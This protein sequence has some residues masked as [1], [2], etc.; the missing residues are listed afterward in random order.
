[1]SKKRQEGRM[2]PASKNTGRAPNLSPT[3]T[4]YNAWRISI[5]AFS[6]WDDDDSGEGRLYANFTPVIMIFAERKDWLVWPGAQ[7]RRPR[8]CTVIPTDEL[9]WNCICEVLC[10]FVTRCQSP[11]GIIF[12]ISKKIYLL[13][14]VAKSY[15]RVRF[16]VK[17]V[18][19]SFRILINTFLIRISI[20]NY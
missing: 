1:M 3:Y 9:F 19:K 17:N 20:F 16:L 6:M 15:K 5:P 4:S 18:W 2:T 7:L 10:F 14:I 11:Q 13:E 8:A 12:F